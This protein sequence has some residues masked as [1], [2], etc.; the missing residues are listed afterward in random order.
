ML[1]VLERREVERQLF[2]LCGWEGDDL[3]FV[4]EFLH[5]LKEK[6]V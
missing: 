6:D 2:R 3:G 5:L 4:G 1:T